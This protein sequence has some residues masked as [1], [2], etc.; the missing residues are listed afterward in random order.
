MKN[1]GLLV[2]VIDDDDATCR[3]IARLLGAMGYRVRAYTTA[4]EF[5]EETEAATPSCVLADILMPEVDGLALVRA[6]HDAGNDIP[7]IFMTAT[8]H[9][10]TVVEAMK[11]GAV[12]L[13][14]KPFSEAALRGAIERAIDSSRELRAGHRDTIEL[15]RQV[16]RLTPREAEVCALVASGMPNKRVAARLG[17]K[18][19]TIKV[20]RGRV[21]QKLQLGTLPELVRLVDSLAGQHVQSIKLDGME[22]AR[23]RAAEIILDVIARERA[24]RVPLV[25]EAVDQQTMPHVW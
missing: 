1:D 2:A 19:K 14:A 17:T 20:H 8:G 11:A 22:F 24:S 7:A 6:M 3:G 18:E 13:L 4:N 21:M 23:P 12:D 15:W 16:R 25:P 10:P 5:L 9:V